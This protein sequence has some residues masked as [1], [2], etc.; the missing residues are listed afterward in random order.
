MLPTAATVFA[1]LPRFLRRHRLMT[2]WMALTGE[3]AIQL[4][5]VREGVRGYA[6]MRDGFLRLIVID[7]DFEHDFFRLADQLVPAGG[8]FLDAGANYGL[9]S[10]GLAA[11]R[12]DVECHLFEPDERL[13]AAIRRTAALYPEARL[14]INATALGDQEGTLGFHIDPVQSG[15][16]HVDSA[17][18]CQVPVRT[19]DEY[20]AQHQISRIDLLKIDVE[21][22]ELRVLE[23]ARQSLA[24]GSIRAIYFEY[25]EKWLRRYQP[26]AHL[27]EFLQSMGYDVCFCRQSDL[28]SRRGAP[29]R[30]RD[31]LA[32]AGLE[33]LP[34]R[35]QSLPEMT[36]LLA[37]PS[38]SLDAQ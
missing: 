1:R 36:D 37:V 24:K 34:V 30:I 28:A 20:L 8:L 15:V 7:G 25:F 27:L 11:L 16:S 31:G 14:T 29:A 26:P 6:D 19:V 12:S 38:G 10:I 13:V 4:V 33:L 17:S 3:D 32:G 9:L 2:A 23:G 5:P 21:G 18:A 22:Y 35:G